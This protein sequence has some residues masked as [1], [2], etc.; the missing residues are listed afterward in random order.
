[1]TFTMLNPHEP[2]LAVVASLSED[3]LQYVEMPLG[4]V[5]DVDAPPQLAL[6]PPAPLRD[7]WIVL[8]TPHAK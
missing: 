4:A 5:H 3:A 6:A 7:T 1:M 2:P 8:P